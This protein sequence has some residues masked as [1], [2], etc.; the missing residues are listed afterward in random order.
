[1]EMGQDEDSEGSDGGQAMLVLACACKCLA[2][3]WV[4][5][6]GWMRGGGRRGVIKSLFSGDASA[7]SPPVSPS[8]PPPCPGVSPSWGPRGSADPWEVRTSDSQVRPGPGAAQSFL[9]SSCPHVLGSVGSRRKEG[10]IWV[11]TQPVTHFLIQM[12]MSGERDSWR[13]RGGRAGCALAGP[14]PVALI[15]CVSPFSS[16]SAHLPAP[17]LQ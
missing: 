12:L 14:H 8:L 3:V 5:R 11:P 4:P 17:S 9:L 7:L 13:V 1:M 2:P 6:A 16:L 15:R 10:A